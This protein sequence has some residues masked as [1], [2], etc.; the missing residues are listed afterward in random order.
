M[1]E[2]GRIL[3]D[4]LPGVPRPGEAGRVD[5]RDRP[6]SGE[7]HPGPRRSRP[8][9]GTGVPGDDLRV[10]QRRGRAR[11]SRGAPPAPGRRHHRAR[12][13]GDREGLL[14]RR[15]GDHAGG[16][17]HRRG[18]AAARRHAGVPG[19]GDRPGA[20]PGRRLGDVSAAV[21]Q[22]VEAAGFGVVR[23]FVG[24]GIGRALHEDPQV[25]NF[26]EAGT[27]LHLRAG[28]VLALEPMVTMGDW[29]VRVPADRWTA[30]P[31]TGAWRRISSTPWR[32]RST[33]P[34]CSAD[35]G[36]G[37][38]ARRRGQCREER[39]GKMPKEEAIEVEGNGGRAP[40]ERDVPGGAGE[41]APVLAHVSGKMR[42]HFIRILPGR[43]GQGRAVAVRPHAGPDLVPVQVDGAR[44]GERRVMKVRPSVKTDCPKCKVI[45]RKGVV[46]VICANARHKQRQG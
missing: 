36:G 24:H 33:A 39:E 35:A 34:R 10:D 19:S 4:A 2:A 28:M 23:A 8:S 6:R 30:V 41:Q 45:R 29:E 38:M 15:R 7:P 18:P 42:M 25:P 40:A 16:R 20:G 1:R 37:L 14:R 22:H 32:S 12:P 13:G 5:P 46:R 44:Q 11:D 9:R 43:Q 3:A 27:G 31:R 21:Q 17:G 26:G